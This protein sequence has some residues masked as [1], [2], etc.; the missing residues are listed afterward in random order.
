VELLHIADPTLV[1]DGEIMADVAVSP[2]MLEQM[3][4]FSSLKGGANV[5]IF[6]DLNS[7]NIACKLLSK[8]GGAET[9][10]PVLMG[11]SKPVHVVQYGAEVEEIV[12]TAAMAVVDAQEMEVSGPRLGV[13]LAVSK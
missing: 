10:G 8:I 12:S 4:P 1:V 7:A 11:M 9:L 5:L 3:Y 13:A 2:A 6:P